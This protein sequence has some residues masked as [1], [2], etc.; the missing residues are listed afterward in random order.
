MKKRDK[1]SSVLRKLIK[2][3]VVSFDVFDTLLLRPVTNPDDVFLMLSPQYNL[4]N[5]CETR[6]VAE[7]SV[8]DANL[9]HYGHRETTIHEI[10]Q[11]MSESTL[12]DVEQG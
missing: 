8:R 7:A 5:F 10:Y 6:R 9:E 12:L 1:I 3:D 11:K 2:Y 4:I